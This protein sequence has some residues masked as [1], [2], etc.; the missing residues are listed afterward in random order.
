MAPVTATNVGMAP[1][2]IDSPKLRALVD[3]LNSFEVNPE[4]SPPID[5]LAVEL[6]DY[7]TWRFEEQ[8]RIW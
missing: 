4:E 6:S 3:K 1:Q 5:A 2:I 7:A 8:V